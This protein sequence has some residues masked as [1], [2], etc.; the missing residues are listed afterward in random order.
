MPCVC[1]KPHGTLP[2]G[3]QGKLGHFHEQH[4]Q[5]KCH[6]K[7]DTI[8]IKL[9]CVKRGTLLLY[10]VLYTFFVRYVLLHYKFIHILFWQAS[11]ASGAN[12][13]S[14]GKSQVYYKRKANVLTQRRSISEYRK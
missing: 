5:E 3:A 13:A 6:R 10:A 4:L 8:V 12:V 7:T 9:L 2:L 11:Q 1:L 14:S